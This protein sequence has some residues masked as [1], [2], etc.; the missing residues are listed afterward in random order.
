MPIHIIIDG[1]NLIRQS[2]SLGALDRRELAAGREALITRLAAYRRLKPH[3]ITVVFDGQ[4]APEASPARDRLRGIAVVYSRAGES[5]DALIVEMTR[6][7]RESALVVSS[8]HA[9]ARGA[10]RNGATVIGSPEFE[11]RMAL[12][13]AMEGAGPPEEGEPARRISTRKRGEGYRLSKRMRRLGLKTG[14]L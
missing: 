1:Y 12:A 11:S 8:D 10:E 14:K 2:P 4:Q 5:A 6:R 9:V 3:R 7:E 13:A